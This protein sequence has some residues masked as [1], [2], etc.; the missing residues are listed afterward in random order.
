MFNTYFTCHPKIQ[1]QKT[2]NVQRMVNEDS[3]EDGEDDL[4]FGGN[5]TSAP[6]NPLFLRLLTLLSCVGGF[7]FGYDTGVVS[8]AMVLVSQHFSLNP[9]WHSAIV[10]VTV[11]IIIIKEGGP[12]KAINFYKRA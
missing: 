2:S 9:W 4:F 12:M 5:V 11:N 7:L 8:G 1:F 3:E 10:S 6:S